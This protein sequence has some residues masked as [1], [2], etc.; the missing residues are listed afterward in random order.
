[1]VDPKPKTDIISRI[2]RFL[3][4]KLRIKTPSW[5]DSLPRVPETI[6]ANWHLGLT[7]FGGPPVQ[8]QM[9][10]WNEVILYETVYLMETL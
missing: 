7:A 4:K 1:M 3:S 8:F 6:A 10:S 5:L 9:V 2:K